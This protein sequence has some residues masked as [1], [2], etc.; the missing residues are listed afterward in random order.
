MGPILR[1]GIHG[2][3]V[4][5]GL[6]LL[7]VAFFLREDEEKKVQNSLEALWV[8]ISD[9]KSAKEKASAL[10]V[11]ISQIALRGI[12]RVFGRIG[13]QTFAVSFCIS[14]ASLLALMAWIGA[15]GY[16]YFVFSGLLIVVAFLPAL[17]QKRWALTICSLPLFLGAALIPSIFIILIVLII[18][19]DKPGSFQSVTQ[20]FARLIDMESDKTIAL[21][22]LVLINAFGSLFATVF[23]T[24]I[25]RVALE[26]AARRGTLRSV[27][28]A[29]VVNLLTLVSMKVPN[30]SGR[31]HLT[32]SLTVDL[33]LVFS[34]S[35]T[36]AVLLFCILIA[37]LVY[38][39]GHPVIWRLIERPVYALARHKVV[40]N[41]K[42]L[43]AV[44]FALLA[45]GLNAP[46]WL[47][48][49]AKPFG[50]KL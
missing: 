7:Y 14:L 22:L 2:L 35:N 28:I 48:S 19:P 13:R 50:L 25:D 43:G 24:I 10:I 34:A 15:L 45:W 30:P 4:C 49:I 32:D 1:Y 29:L 46:Q 6:L 26:W 12:D 42:L 33:Q 18:V 17:F 20:F 38:V 16:T 36:V 47:L 5:A 23:Y 37:V 41:H 27:I 8:R 9:L 40:N 39:V 21:T 3:A 44:G 11:A 31:V